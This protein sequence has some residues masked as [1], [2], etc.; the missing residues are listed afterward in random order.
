MTDDLLP[1]AHF[2][3][4]RKLEGVY[5]WHLTRLAV[6]RSLL[7]SCRLNHPAVLDLGCGTG[8]FLETLGNDLKASRAVGVDASK[9][10][11]EYLEERHIEH[12]DADLDTPLVVRENGFQL[13]TAMDVLEHL[14]HPENLVKTA[15]INLAPGGFFLASVPAHPFLYSDWDRMLHH[16]CRFTKKAL[17]DL[18]AT[19][20]FA[21]RHLTHAFF[22]PFFPAVALRKRRAKSPDTREEFPPI[23]N[24][25]NRLLLIEGRLEASWLRF[26]PLPTG[27][28][29]YILAQKPTPPAIP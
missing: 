17:K 4:L 24:W 16:V 8:A 22:A 11:L 2:R 7:R 5:W 18:V 19:R 14:P 26:A 10:A 1:T 29:L 15:W 20:N 6:S 28:S 9:T 25:L 12:L 13:V 21:I 23:P 27:L 3:S